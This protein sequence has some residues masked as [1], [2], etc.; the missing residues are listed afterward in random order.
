MTLD[1]HFIKDKEVISGPYEG[2]DK[3]HFLGSASTIYTDKLS[4][5]MGT[6][7][8]PALEGRLSGLNITQYRGARVHQTSA[9][10]TSDIVGNVPVFGEGFYSDNT[11]FN[12]GSRGIAPRGGN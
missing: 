8:L 11:E 1:E 12:V 7:I 9:N 6:T 3:N 5:M 2:K 4:S 10:S